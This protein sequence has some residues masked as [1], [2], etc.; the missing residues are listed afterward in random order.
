MSL[1]AVQSLAGLGDVS[2]VLKSKYPR[3]NR[4]LSI[5]EF[6]GCF[7]MSFAWP[8]PAGGKLDLYLHAVVDLGYKYVFFMTITG[9]FLLKLQTGLRSSWPAPTGVSLTQKCSADTLR[10][11]VPHSVTFAS[12][13]PIM[14]TGAAIQ[15]RDAPSTSPFSLV[16]VRAC[17][18]PHSRPQVDKLGRPILSVGGA[19][20]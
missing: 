16:P 10:V 11:F 20:I 9:H 1:L 18:P 6:V 8:M 12:P 19:S 14:Q 7:R 17:R 13:T 4:K 15:V 3:L 5:A 2:V